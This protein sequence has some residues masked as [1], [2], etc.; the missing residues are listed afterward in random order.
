MLLSTS[1]KH[2]PTVPRSKDIEKLPKNK[3]MSDFEDGLSSDGDDSGDELLTSGLFKVKESDKS[4][5]M[6]KMQSK[7]FL[8][9]NEIKSDCSGLHIPA[10]YMY[11]MSFV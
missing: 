5:K 7:V 9:S 1:S 10:M 2:L 8:T 6:E 3:R 11:F 4:E